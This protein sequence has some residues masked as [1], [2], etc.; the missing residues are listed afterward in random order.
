MLYLTRLD[1]QGDW[2]LHPSLSENFEDAVILKKSKVKRP[3]PQRMVL[4]RCCIPGVPREQC[5][6]EPSNQRVFAGPSQIH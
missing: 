6:P 5:L 1:M 2:K 3:G 4:R